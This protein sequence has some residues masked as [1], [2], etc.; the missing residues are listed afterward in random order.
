MG[1][2]DHKSG[3]GASHSEGDSSMMHSTLETQFVLRFV[4]GKEKASWTLTANA[5]NGIV[6]Q[7]DI[8]FPGS[9]VPW[10]IQTFPLSRQAARE[11][12]EWLLERTD[13]VTPSY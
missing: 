4:P 13:E 5:E 1:R 9:E 11:I 3:K 2:G 10:I 8:P 7:I 12:G 6:W